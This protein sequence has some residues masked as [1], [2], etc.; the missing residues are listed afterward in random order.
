M[1]DNIGKN[2]WPQNRRYSSSMISQNH[3]GAVLKARRFSAISW[4]GLPWNH[5]Q[6][7]IKRECLWRPHS[8]SYIPFQWSLCVAHRH[9]ASLKIAGPQGL[10]SPD[11]ISSSTGTFWTSGA[12]GSNQSCWML[13]L[14][15][16][17]H[18]PILL[19]PCWQAYRDLPARI[20]HEPSDHN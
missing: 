15:S 13:R 6:R 18:L 19:H 12:A 17:N 8:S 9:H 20:R 4:P 14:P 16:Q 5:P 7:N 1:T 10:E 2:T 3:E 11:C